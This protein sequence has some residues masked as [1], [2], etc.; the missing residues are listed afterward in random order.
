[1][2]GTIIELLNS[3]IFSSMNF[4]VKQAIR[5]KTGGVTDKLDEVT[6]KCKD[7]IKSEED[8]KAFQVQDEEEKIQQEVNF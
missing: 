8:E 4:V 7:M 6:R 3:T 5:S 1:M 2:Y